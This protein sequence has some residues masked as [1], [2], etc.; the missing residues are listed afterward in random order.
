MPHHTVSVSLCMLFV[1]FIMYTESF[2]ES[3]SSV[4]TTHLNNGE[5]I[6][7]KFIHYICS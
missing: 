3:V 6:N 4:S 1:I 5:L 2:I 7:S